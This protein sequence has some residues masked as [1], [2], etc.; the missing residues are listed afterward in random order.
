MIGSHLTKR[1]IELGRDVIVV[2]D[3]SRGNELNFSDLGIKPEI[4][5]ID[6]DSHTVP[7]LKAKC[8]ERGIKGSSQLKKA[9]LIARLKESPS[10]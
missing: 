1:L 7:E 2:D 8:K 4:K 5:K 3:F 10:D 9:E 6:Y